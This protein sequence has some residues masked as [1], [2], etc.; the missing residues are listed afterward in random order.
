LPCA[1]VHA[2]RLPHAHHNVKQF[3]ESL[4]ISNKLLSLEFCI[5][6]LLHWILLAFRMLILLE[7]VLTKR[8]L[9]VPAI[10]S[11]PLLSAGLLGNNLQLLNP[12]QRLSM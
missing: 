10:F 2:L 5:L 4:G 11:D 8:A 12:P 6:L 1:C 7:G 3:S 9:R